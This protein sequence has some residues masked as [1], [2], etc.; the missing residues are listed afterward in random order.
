[1]T[2]PGPVPQ[3]NERLEQRIAQLERMVAEMQRK[4]L[5]SAVISGGGVTITDN[6]V[7]S[8]ETADGVLMLFLGPLAAGLVQYRGLLINREDG[9]RM[10]EMGAV[11]SDPDKIYFAWKDRGNNIVLSDDGI[12]GTGLARPWIPIPTAP[13]H[14]SMIPMTSSA[15]YVPTYGTALALQQ[16][17]CLRLQALY[18][19]TG[20]ATG[21][22][23]FTLNGSPIGT[24]VP[25]GAGDYQ[26]STAQNVVLPT[27]YNDNIRIEVE[28]QV[29]NAVGTVGAVLWAAGRQSF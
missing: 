13:I 5:H 8:V 23:R 15:T 1:M 9:S 14:A 4:T 24:V 21:N 25:I 11:L 12:A 19:S 20:G 29:T 22:M 16:H 3:P 7:L 18:R 17:P 6:G 2:L 28:V 27:A 10:F 26:Y